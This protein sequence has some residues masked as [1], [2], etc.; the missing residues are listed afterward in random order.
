MLKKIMKKSFILPLTF[1]VL[2]IA[3]CGSLSAR[4]EKY[5]SPTGENTI[6]VEYDFVSRPTVYYDGEVIWKYSGAGF[7]E[8][9]FFDV[10]WI[11]EETILLK[12]KDEGHDGKYAEEFEVDIKK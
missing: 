7:Q 8:E 2:L 10:S 9:V 11:N 6:V 1:V 12:Y 5:T 4:T 3:A